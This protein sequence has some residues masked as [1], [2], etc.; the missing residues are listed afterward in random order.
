MGVIV[1]LVPKMLLLLSM[2]WNYNVIEFNIFLNVFKFV[3]NVTALEVFLRTNGVIACM[4]VLISMAIKSALQR[5]LL[6]FYY[7][8]DLIGK[9]IDTKMSAKVFPF[10]LSTIG[11]SHYLTQQS[12][13]NMKYFISA[14]LQIFLI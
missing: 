5:L 6:S 11:E 13:E 10:I 14:I 3:T 1:S 7:P 9:L 2:V 12:V 4:L 8:F